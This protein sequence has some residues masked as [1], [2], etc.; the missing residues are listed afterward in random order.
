MNILSATQNIIAHF[1]N[2][3]LHMTS[4]SVLNGTFSGPSNTDNAKLLH[5]R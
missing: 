4:P 2:V 3:Q 1:A 5:Q